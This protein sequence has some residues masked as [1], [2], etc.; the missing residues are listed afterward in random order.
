MPRAMNVMCASIFLMINLGY[1]EIY[2]LG[3]DHSWLE[4]FYVNERNQVILGDKHFYGDQSVV[5][6]YSLS[7]WL[8]NVSTGF[9]THERLSEYANYMGVK[10]Y[11]ATEGSYID[12]YERKKII[13]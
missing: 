1:R 7:K 6:P 10:V 4:S 13:G 5:C 12:A 11:N 8:Q 3:A 2:L 9:R